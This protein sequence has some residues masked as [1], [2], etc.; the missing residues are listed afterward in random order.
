MSSAVPYRGKE[1]YVFISYAHKDAARVYPILE[2]VQKDLYR[3]WFDE[4]IDPGTEWDEFIA[5]QIIGCGY[6]IAFISKNYLASGNCKDEL[7][8]ARDLEKHRLLVYLEE[9]TLPAGMAMRMNRIQSVFYYRYNDT[10]AFYKNLYS[11][12]GLSAFKSAQAAVSTQ[13]SASGTEKTKVSLQ[14]PSS[15]AGKRDIGAEMKTLFASFRTA[16]KNAQI[17]TLTYDSGAR[18]EG[19]VQNG[20]ANGYGTYRYANGNRYEGQ[21]K[22]GKKHGT[23]TFHFTNSDVYKGQWV[24]DVKV[25]L[26]AYYFNSGSVYEGDWEGGKMQGFGRLTFANGD[27]YEGDWKNDK[28][29]GF[30]ILRFQNGSRYEGEWLESNMHGNGKYFHANGDLYDGAWENDQKHGYG[31]YKHAS[32]D[33]YEGMWANGS[34]NGYGVYHF[35][36]GSIYE[37]EWVDGKMCGQGKLTKKDGQVTEGIWADDKFVG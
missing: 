37:G 10:N 5:N 26:G 14:A 31:T 19:E 35:P 27:V 9:V 30:G 28:R 22:D 32:G 3:I 4:G 17:E 8:Y 20:K 13:N 11:A 29:T 15:F 25:G 18:Y 23:G 24:E 21:W 16:P 12:D 2:Q 6:F 7:N 1:P 34:K 33:L 36:S